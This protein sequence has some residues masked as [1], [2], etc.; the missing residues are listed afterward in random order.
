MLKTNYQN[1][2][3][4]GID[5]REFSSLK[6]IQPLC[7]YFIGMGVPYILYHCDMPRGSK[8]YNR[9]S[10]KNIKASSKKIVKHARHVR[11]YAS[12]AALAGLLLADNIKKFVGVELFLCYKNIAVDLQNKGINLYSIL[13]LTDDIWNSNKKTYEKI[14]RTYFCSKYLMDIALKFSGANYNDKKHKCVGSPLFDQLSGVGSGGATLVLLPNINSS[15]VSQSFGSKGN[16]IN[17]VKKLSEQND[18]IFKT[19][20]KQWLPAEIV[21]YSKEIINDGSS[22]YPSA[23]VDAF[24]KCKNVVMFYSSGVYEAVAAD[25]YV[26]NI[27][28]PL[29]RWRWD[30]TKMAEYFSK[31]Q[32]SLYNF[33]GVVENIEQADVISGNFNLS[34]T[35]DIKQRDAWIGKYLAPFGYN[36]IKKMAEDIVK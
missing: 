18:L 33:N 31:K 34:K 10:L 29:K 9:A 1:T 27:P 3:L 20:K 4:V 30:K 2:G 17:I 24:S 25:R 12:N 26:I 23:I 16:F 21:K 22:M 5:V 32:G 36:S 15:Q 28:L 35:I 19:R 13:Y 6:I 7:E 14:H 8:E 11:P